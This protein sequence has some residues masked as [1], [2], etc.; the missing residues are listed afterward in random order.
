MCRLLTQSKSY[1]RKSNYFERF[2]EENGGIH[3]IEDIIRRILIEQNFKLTK[4]QEI[5]VGR[6]MQ[7][8]NI[9]AIN[10]NNGQLDM[11][12]LKAQVVNI[13][14]LVI[15]IRKNKNYLTNDLLKL[16]VHHTAIIREHLKYTDK[17]LIH[18]YD[19]NHYDYCIEW[20]KN[21]IIMLDNKIS[22]KEYIFSKI[23]E[24]RDFVLTK[25][26]NSIIL[27]NDRL[28]KSI[29]KISIDNFL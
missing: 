8:R 27:D 1:E 28:N 24:I 16:L 20:F 29:S 7:G 26:K 25:Q 21:C 13:S 5:F 2:I 14:C 12:H 18:D 19:I 15:H 23:R 22:D 6:I 9:N 11:R 17:L 4:L 10:E 3:F